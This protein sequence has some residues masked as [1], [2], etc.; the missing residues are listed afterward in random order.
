[1]GS[2]PWGRPQGFSAQG[3]SVQGWGSSEALGWGISF[4]KEK[5]TSAVWEWEPCDDLRVAPRPG[6]HP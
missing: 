1:M 2:L 4:V 5:E 3:F 6:P